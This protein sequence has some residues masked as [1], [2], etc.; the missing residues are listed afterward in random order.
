MEYAQ[1]LARAVYCLRV[2]GG[3][4]GDAFCSR[5][6][7]P[8]FLTRGAEGNTASENN[9]STQCEAEPGFW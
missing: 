8:Q 5:V 4:G 6:F 3:G 7:L 1:S 9:R 2:D